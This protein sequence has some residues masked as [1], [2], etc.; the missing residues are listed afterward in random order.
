MKLLIIDTYYPNFLKSFWKS[1]PNLKN[2]NYTQQIKKLLDQCFGTSDFYSYNLQKLGHEAYDII[3]NDDIS[4]K[5]WAKEHKVNIVY[6]NLLDKLRTR[7]YVNKII[8]KPGWIQKIVL[9]QIEFYQP[10]VI[11]IQDL[12]VLT[13][14]TLTKIKR[15][16]ILVVG[17]VACPINQ[18]V[19]LKTFDLILTSFPHYVKLFRKLGIKSEY[20]KIGFEPR[21]L[22]KIKRTKKKYDVTFIGS[23]SPHHQKATQALENVAQ[24][25]PI[26]V[27]GHGLKYLSKNSPLKKNYHGEAWGLDMYKVMARSK[28]VINRHIDVAE[29][30]ANNMR[31]YEST[32]IG[33]MLI[34]DTKRNLNQLF[35][36]GKE[37]DSY[38][39][40]EELTRK[41]KYY[42]TNERKRKQIAK[43]GQKRTLKEH[44]YQKRMQELVLILN[45]YI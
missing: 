43:A 13:Q 20:F 18:E 9:S 34:T 21:V 29:N 45:K 28:I 15:K 35:Q 37:I 25:I 10:K 30:Y 11:Y 16:G 2:K 32:G 12:N 6:S 19:S 42:L 23:F 22:T 38:T 14:K 1:N 33:A 26:Q 5:Q 24:K 41:L 4:Q 40:E 3:A 7:P 36:I 27:W 8:G 44:S 31:L 17:Q 39:N